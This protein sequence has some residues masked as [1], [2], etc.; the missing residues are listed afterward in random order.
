M[1]ILLSYQSQLKFYDAILEKMAE[2]DKGTLVFLTSDGWV[3]LSS[4]VLQ[5]VSPLVKD[6]SSKMTSSVQE[7]L[8]ISLQE[9][10]SATVDGASLKGT[11]L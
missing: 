5:I 4:K 1:A 7:P 11:Y 2:E 10:K 3:T 8:F 9:F 6:I